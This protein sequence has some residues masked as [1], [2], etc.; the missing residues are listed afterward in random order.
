MLFI[1]GVAF[2]VAKLGD[3]PD[4]TRAASE[5]GTVTVPRPR[6]TLAPTTTTLTVLPRVSLPPVTTARPPATSPPGS[7]RPASPATVVVPKLVGMRLGQATAATSAAGL[8]IA[9]PTYCDDV[10]ASQSPAAG[11]R[12]NRG[13]RVSV[14]LVPCVVPKVV[15]MRLEAAKRAIAAAKLRISWPDY[16]DDVVH[17]QSPAAGKKVD[18]GTTVSVQLAPPGSC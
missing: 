2:V 18:P 3:G 5:N 15:G 13:S 16:C 6:T 17:G 7:P 9:W 14:G 4:T 1:A 12:V 11:A 8:S 10:V